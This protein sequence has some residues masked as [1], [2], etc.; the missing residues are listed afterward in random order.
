MML[1]YT[2]DMRVLFGGREPRA[3]PEI[4]KS[5]KEVRLVTLYLEV[6]RS[7]ITHIGIIENI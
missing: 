2:Y 7:A 1:G 4:L 5:G 6:P 3:I